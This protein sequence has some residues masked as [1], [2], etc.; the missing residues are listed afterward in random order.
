MEAEDHLAREYVQE[1]VLDHL[2]PADVKR[3]VR[4]I[5]P[6]SMVNPNGQLPSQPHGLTLAPLTPPAHELEQPHPLY[7]QPHIQVQHGVLVKAPPGA[8]SHLTTLSHPGTPPDTPPVS[9]SPPPLQLH[10]GEREHR[11]RNGLLLHLQQ[12]SSLV[13]DEIPVSSGGM[14]WLTQSLRQEPLD[15]RPHCPQDQTPEPPPEH[16]TSAPSHHHFQELQHIPRHMRHAGGYITMPSHL[17]Y[18]GS[19][20]PGPG[21]GMLP[22]G[23]VVMQSM[24]DSMQ[25]MPMQPGRPL[26]VCSVSSCS[27]NGQSH[28]QPKGISS[29]YSNCG[30]NGSSVLMSDE[31]LMSLSV[32]ELNK[33]LQ[34]YPRDEKLCCHQ[35]VRLKQ[36]RRTLKNRGYAQNCRSKRQQQRQ[37][38]ETTNQNLQN[39]LQRMQLEIDQ[40][41]QERD[42]YKQRWELLRVRQNHNHHSHNHNHSHHQPPSQQQH[43]V[44]N[45][46]HQP[47]P[48]SPEVY[49]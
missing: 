27:A 25:G 8:A 42:L 33:R 18:Y 12:P 40:I 41:R 1:F 39:K 16:W 2:D 5:S 47:A 22:G 49:L 34:G 44:Q 29:S 24:D 19:G 38:L 14:G 10:R 15:L 31:V 28:G 3:E 17:D 48:A 46:Q 7:G 21:G 26:S 43:Q 30:S 37:D 36:K 6:T 9:A 45:Q 32:R 23:G 35:V 20:G 4:L 11:D 13:Q